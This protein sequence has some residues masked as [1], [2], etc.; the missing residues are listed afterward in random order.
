MI[1]SDHLDLRD[2]HLVA[3]AAAQRYLSDGEYVVRVDCTSG[4]VS[5]FIMAIFVL[6]QI[7]VI[8]AGEPTYFR[9]FFLGAG[10]LIGVL[11]FCHI[12]LR[13]RRWQQ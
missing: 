1:G 3:M 11:L 2:P 9:L 8:A 12:I 4:L 10:V 7:L 13:A 5:I 6:L